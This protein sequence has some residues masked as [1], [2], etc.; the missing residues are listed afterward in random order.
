MYEFEYDYEGKQRRKAIVLSAVIQFAVLFV[1]RDYRS[2]PKMLCI[3][4][5]AITSVGIFIER[6]NKTAFIVVQAVKMILWLIFLY[7]KL[8]AISRYMV[9]SDVKLSLLIVYLYAAIFPFLYYL[10][11][12]HEYE[13]PKPVKSCYLEMEEEEYSKRLTKSLCSIAAL[14]N[15]AF[16]TLHFMPCGT[17]TI[18]MIRL[19]YEY[20]YGLDYLYSGKLDRPVF[21]I[22][23]S[24]II[25][26]EWISPKFFIVSERIKCILSILFSFI[27][28]LAIVINLSDYYYVSKA[29]IYAFWFLT[30]FLPYTIYSKKM[31]KLMIAKHYKKQDESASEQIAQRE[32]TNIVQ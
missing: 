5:M 22:F 6:K 7:I 32:N 13:H 30:L 31:R 18:N 20:E 17:D 19:H 9:F 11:K 26:L 3:F 1:L 24:L 16:I 10:I 12:V 29:A 28:V 15:A 2:T 27:G 8:K 4:L 23:I 25:L 21:Y 14:Q